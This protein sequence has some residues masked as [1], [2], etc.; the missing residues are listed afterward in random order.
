MIS[1]RLSDLRPE[2]TDSLAKQA[3][4]RIP[5]R[6]TMDGIGNLRSVTR[7]VRARYEDGRYGGGRRKV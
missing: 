4:G 1:G 5:R 6:G 7:R 2:R 3:F